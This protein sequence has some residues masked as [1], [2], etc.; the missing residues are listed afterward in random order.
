MIFSSS[1]YTLLGLVASCNASNYTYGY[2][3]LH[4]MVCLSVCRLLHSTPCLNRSMD[5]GAIWQVHLWGP[6]THCV[7]WGDLG[8]NPSQNMQLQISDATCECK[9]E[10][11]DSAFYQITLVRI[12]II[13]S[14]SGSTTEHDILDVAKK[15]NNLLGAIYCIVCI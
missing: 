1:W 14:I 8:S 6:M 5:L 15:E 12:I 9:W 3:F 11:S 7:R 4:S 13:I 10:F 2:T